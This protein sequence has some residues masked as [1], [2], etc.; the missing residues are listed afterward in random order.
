[1]YKGRVG[2]RDGE[3]GEVGGVLT[4]PVDIIG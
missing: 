3:G 4:L 2:G 1:M